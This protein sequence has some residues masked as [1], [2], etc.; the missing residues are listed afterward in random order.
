MLDRIRSAWN[1]LR[2]YSAA[3]D[4]RASSWSPSA[5]SANAEVAGAA[6]TVARRARDAVRN[7]PYAARIVDLWTA[8]AV[9][10]GICA[11]RHL[12]ECCFCKLK[13]FRRVATRFEK[14]AR[15]YLAVVTLAATIPWLR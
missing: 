11:Q 6:A 10:A 5:G 12:I 3:A 2:G 7:D 14:T 13:Q 4:L 15:N 1:A 8:N 9:G